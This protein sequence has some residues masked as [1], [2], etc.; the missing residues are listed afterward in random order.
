MDKDI[1]SKFAKTFLQKRIQNRIIFELESDKKRKTAIYRFC[2]TTDDIVKP[3]FVLYK[4]KKLTNNDIL[5]II[6]ELITETSCYI[7]CSF[8]EAIDGTKTTILNALLHCIGH[9][10]PS[11]IIIGEQIAIIETE[12]EQGASYKYILHAI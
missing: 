5:Q 12:Q 3:Q 2:H 1:E 6:N 8:D 10:M 9:G 7:I 11:I 4:T